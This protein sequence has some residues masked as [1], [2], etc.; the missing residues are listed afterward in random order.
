[1][2][3]LLPLLAL[4]LAC[5]SIQIYRVD[6]RV[7]GVHAEEQSLEEWDH[8]RLNGQTHGLRLERGRQQEE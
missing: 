8:C 1:M 5:D 4:L 2:R 7:V 6:G 3:A